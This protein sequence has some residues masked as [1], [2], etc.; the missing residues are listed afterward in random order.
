M[1]AIQALFNPVWGFLADRTRRRKLVTVSVHSL[2]CV[3]VIVLA[4]PQVSCHGCFWSIT[5]VALCL[6][7]TSTTFGVACTAFVLDFL[8]DSRSGQ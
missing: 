6:A 1:L 8:G 3:S 2:A 4:L 5:A 7:A